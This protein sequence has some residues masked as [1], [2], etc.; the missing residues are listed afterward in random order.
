MG[1]LKAIMEDLEEAVELELMKGR[2]KVCD[3]IDDGVEF[4]CGFELE[5]YL[6]ASFELELNSLFYLS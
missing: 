1:E 5:F 3:L 6:F 4:E 2:P